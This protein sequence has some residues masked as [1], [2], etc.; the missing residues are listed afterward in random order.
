MKIKSRGTAAFSRLKNN[1]ICYI[2][3][4][5]KNKNEKRDNKKS[6]HGVGVDSL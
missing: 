3:K 5:E 1:R 4:K 2:K 6:Q